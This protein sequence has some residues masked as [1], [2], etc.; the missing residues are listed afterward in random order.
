MKYTVTVFAACLLLAVLSSCSSTYVPTRAAYEKEL[1]EILGQHEDNALINYGK[2]DEVMEL[3]EG[4]KVLVYTKL[5]YSVSPLTETKKYLGCETKFVVSPNSKI[6]KIR[7][8]G[9]F[10]VR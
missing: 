4:W 8:D 6:E 2:P 5:P 7:A 3:A 9:N 10:C 1:K